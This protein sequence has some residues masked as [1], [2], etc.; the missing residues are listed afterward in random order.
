MVLSFLAHRGAYTFAGS[1]DPR[2]GSYYS[3]SGYW[4][5]GNGSRYSG[6]GSNETRHMKIRLDINLDPGPGT[7]MLRPIYPDPNTQTQIPRPIYWDPCCLWTH[8]FGPKC[9]DPG[10]GTH[11]SGPICQDPNVHT[12]ISGPKCSDPG[13]GTHIPRP[14][15]LRA[16]GGNHQLPPVA[17]SFLTLSEVQGVCTTV[18]T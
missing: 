14:M 7:H 10:P 1:W 17:L 8:I 18:K 11:I 15:K 4:V 3:V 2:P 5:R 16:T 6:S 12:H 9:S 13:P